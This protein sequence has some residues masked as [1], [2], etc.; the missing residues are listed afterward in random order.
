[1][2][3]SLIKYGNIIGDV[4]EPCCGQDMAIASVFK[5]AKH[6]VYCNDSN[7]SATWELDASEDE[8]WDILPTC[9]WVITN[10]PFNN[11]LKILRHSLAHARVGVAFLLRV[12]ADEMVMSD[13]DR[14]NFW[15]SNSESLTIKMPRYSFARSSKSGNFCTDSAYCQW[16]VWRKD[17][18]KYPDP[19][20]RLPHDQIAGFTRKPID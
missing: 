20:I 5:Q 10:P 4:L 18:Y 2:T 14:Y 17:G 16:F 3:E 8:S 6:T 13:S 15:A 7:F 9:D 19:V 1:M 11:H 12:T